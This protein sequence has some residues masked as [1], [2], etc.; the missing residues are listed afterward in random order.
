MSFPL[1]LTG[2]TFDTT[3]AKFGQALSGGN[4]VVNSVYPTAAPYTLECWVKTT[5]TMHNTIVMGQQ[6]FGYIGVF[7]GIA[8]S[9]YGNGAAQAHLQTG[10]VSNGAWHHIAL[11]VLTTP[12]GIGQF[13]V[14]YVD[15]VGVAGDS[16]TFAAAGQGAGTQFA[17]GDVGGLLGVVPMIGE[18]DEVAIW[19]IAKYNG[20]FAPPTTAYAG[21]ETGLVALWHL[22]GTGA[23]SVSAAVPTISAPT[24]TGLVA[25]GSTTISGTYANGA[26]SGLSQILDGTTTAVSAPTIS[27]GTYS[28]V[29][30]TPA[31]AAHSI[32]V[33][34][35][36]TNASTGSATSFTTTAGASAT[37]SEASTVANGAALPVTYTLTNIGIAYAVRCINGVEIAAR[38][39][40]TGAS[41]SAS[42]ASTGNVNETVRIFAAAS[43]GTL[44]IESTTVARSL[45]SAGVQSRWTHS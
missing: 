41:G 28:Y 34:G 20:N 11:V 38:Q 8:Q 23:E 39:A 36:G 2:A 27:G 12:T 21:T 32:Q 5:D 16:T 19:N 40:I 35:A 33:N 1:T 14:M 7:N 42:L 29:I 15:G 25:G 44:L 45:S 31:A 6:N 43:G 30:A 24:V 10:T 18:V 26:P 4:G 3:T 22:D 9:S 17:V 13:S 37:V